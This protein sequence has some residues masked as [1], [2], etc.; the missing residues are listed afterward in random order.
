MYYTI[1][2]IF[3]RWWRDRKWGRDLFMQPH[4]RGPNQ[5]RRGWRPKS[6]QL[7]GLWFLRRSTDLSN[8]CRYRVFHMD[9]YK[10]KQVLWPC[11]SSQDTFPFRFMLETC[12]QFDFWNKNFFEFVIGSPLWFGVFFNVF[13]FSKKNNNLFKKSE[14]KSVWHEKH[15]H[16]TCLLL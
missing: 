10:S 8:I 7:V 2:F 16:N 5:F 14:G 3:S 11:F 6:L 12:V 15:G 9:S 1:L 4:Y 13:Y